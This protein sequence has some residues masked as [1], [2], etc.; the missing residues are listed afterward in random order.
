MV[1]A[2]SLAFS[3]FLSVV[4]LDALCAYAQSAGPGAAGPSVASTSTGSGEPPGG[5]AA[6]LGAKLSNPV[7]DVWALF[8]EID[9][10]FSDGDVNEGDP[11]PGA[12]VIFQPVLPFPLYGA[13]DARWNLI[14][15]PIIPVLF[16]QPIPDG[17][18]QFDH[19]GGLGDIQLPMLL[20][21]PVKGWILGA[22]PSWLFPTSTSDEFGRQQW[23][24]GPSAVVGYMTKKVVAGVFPQ[25][26]FG[27]GSRSDRNNEV[28][29]ASYLNLL[30]FLVLNLPD[31]WQVGLNP[32]ISYD[33]QAR[34]G[35]EWNVPIGL[36]AAKTTH[37]GK[38]PVKFQLGLEY[39]VL[40]QDVFGQ[41]AQIKLN[42]IPVIPSL[43]KK[44]LFGGE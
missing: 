13:K 36:I 41:R 40:S 16:S 4:A 30:Y 10:Y 3:L 42:V 12:R 5:G 6:E 20:A 35:N 22:G 44:P 21:P 37:V 26:Y 11:E 2:R 7:S 43:V 39:S 1:G 31:A 25:Y 32:T 27:I 28:D 17:F 19:K 23:G 38:L 29:D 18:D 15:R 14:T 34:S 33:H 9:L 24:V 8:T